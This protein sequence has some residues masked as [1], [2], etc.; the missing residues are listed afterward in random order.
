MTTKIDAPTLQARLREH[1]DTPLIDVLPEEY[2]AAQHLPGARRACVYEVDFL[3]QIQRLGIS[4]DDEVV[5]YGAGDGSL[6]SAV[7]A[8][9]LEGAGFTRLVVFSGG[10]AEW[11]S[12]GGIFEGTA[13]SAPVAATPEDRTYL[14]DPATSTVE[15]IGRNLGSTHRGLVNVA[16]G[17]LSLRNGQLSTGRIDLDMRSI[18]NSNLDD[19]T[20]RKVLEAHL[21][22]DDFFDV[23]R[24]PTAT[25]ALQSASPIPG[26]TPGAP[27]FTLTA[28]LTIK[29]ITHSIE[30]PAI[31]AIGSDAVITS[32]AQ[33]EID[34]T[35]WNVIYG[36]GRF[37]KMLGKHLVNDAITLLVK[38]VAR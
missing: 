33:L 12:A 2:F 36:S 16:R 27:N 25:L 21:K 22:S 34:R 17:E 9:K 28:N 18:S 26:A 38:I 37:F 14:I 15:W 13:S 24:F 31:I 1:S 4:H 7:A 5:L 23:E 30:F 6:D 32:I 3:E 29:G 20:L 10:R 8:E 11:K 35:R 19:P